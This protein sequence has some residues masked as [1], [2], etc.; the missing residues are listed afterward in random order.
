MTASDEEKLPKAKPR[1]VDRRVK[2]DA[3]YSGP[4]RRKGERRSKK[5]K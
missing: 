1:G 4:D 2:E 5:G 3:T